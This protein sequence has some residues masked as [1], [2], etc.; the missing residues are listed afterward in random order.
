MVHVN[1]S[2][3]DIKYVAV[4]KN[5]ISMFQPFHGFGMYIHLLPCFYNLTMANYYRSSSGQHFISGLPEYIIS[6]SCEAI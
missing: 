2:S 1:E 4:E 6:S 5:R 3:P